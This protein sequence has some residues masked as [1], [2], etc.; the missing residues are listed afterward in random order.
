MHHIQ[1]QRTTGL[2]FTEISQALA[3]QDVSKFILQ[4]DLVTRQFFYSSPFKIV[5]LQI[6]WKHKCFLVPYT[7]KH[8]ILTNERTKNPAEMMRM[9]CDREG[10][11]DQRIVTRAV[12]VNWGQAGRRKATDASPG[13]T[14]FI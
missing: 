14:D 12:N 2:S 11:N 1:F 6:R 7:A 5:L 13:P 3:S 10:Q 9:D 4:K 8:G